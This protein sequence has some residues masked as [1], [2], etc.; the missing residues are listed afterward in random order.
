MHP[1]GAF[2]LLVMPDLGGH[3]DRSF[4]PSNERNSVDNYFKTRHASPLTVRTY[5]GPVL[6]FSS[7]G[8]HL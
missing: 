2:T 5:P 3:K 4:K 8:M 7:S 1:D 6:Y